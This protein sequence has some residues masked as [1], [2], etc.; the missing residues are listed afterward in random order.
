MSVHDDVLKT[1]T[2]TMLRETYRL[3]C[4]HFFAIKE[5]SYSVQ[6]LISVVGTVYLPDP[7]HSV[8]M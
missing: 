3:T 4:G 2:M 6:L 7:S 8:V 1:N 5:Q